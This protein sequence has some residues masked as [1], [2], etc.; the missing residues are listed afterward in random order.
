MESLTLNQLA[1]ILAKLFETNEDGTKYGYALIDVRRS[2]INE[3]KKVNPSF[4]ESE[5]INKTLGI[6]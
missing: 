3:I 2:I 1:E 6:K 5:F 4:D